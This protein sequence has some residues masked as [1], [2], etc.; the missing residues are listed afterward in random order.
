MN[1]PK[2]LFQ[3]NPEILAHN[4]KVNQKVNNLNESFQKDV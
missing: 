3:H 2:L 4:D 1:F